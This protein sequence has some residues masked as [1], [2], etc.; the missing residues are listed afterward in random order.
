[1][2]IAS[3]QGVFGQ[4]GGIS[5]YSLRNNMDKGGLIGFKP[6]FAVIS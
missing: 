6:V 1:M 4:Y 3:A 5:P 2:A